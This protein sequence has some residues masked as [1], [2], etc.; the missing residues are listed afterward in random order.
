[1]NHKVLLL[2]VLALIGAAVGVTATEEVMAA[3][4]KLLFV[5]AWTQPATGLEAFTSNIGAFLAGVQGQVA[6]ALE[7]IAGACY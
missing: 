5:P 2:V 4:R 6:G 1:M 7:P 3:N